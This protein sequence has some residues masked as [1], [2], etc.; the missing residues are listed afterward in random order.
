MERRERSGAPLRV[1]RESSVPP[2]RQIAMRL[3][4]QIFEGSWEAGDR[5]PSVR[6]LG[7]ACGVHR[8]TAAAAYRELGRRGLV[9]TIPGGGIYVA[10]RSGPVQRLLAGAAEA[11]PVRLASL[12]AALRLRR[13]L[14]I[15]DEPTLADVVGRELRDL[16]GAFALRTVASD[17]GLLPGVDFGWL[18][19][20][21]LPPGVDADAEAEVTVRIAGRPDRASLRPLLLPVGL[22]SALL[23][24]LAALS[25]PVVVGVL[26][27]SSDVRRM[28]R[29]AVAAVCG[30]EVGFV[31]AASGDGPGMRRLRARATILL[32]DAMHLSAVAT[33]GPRAGGHTR[34]GATG[35]LPL[36]LVPARPATELLGLLGRADP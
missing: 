34:P 17:P 23:E 1:V 30:A 12:A 18:P 10:R 19:V 20:R 9:R 3:E 32:A 21:V 8:D 33:P 28:A 13:V 29:E 25:Y 11:L 7:A 2:R 5:L 35:V 6:S 16:L 15:S 27:A 4:G 36:R 26:S 14:L 24:S 31:A 22:R